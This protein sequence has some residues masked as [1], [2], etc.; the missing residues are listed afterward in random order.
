MCVLE[1]GQG[2]GGRPEASLGK[3]KLQTVE[4]TGVQTVRDPEQDPAF[5]RNPPSQ[6]HCLHTR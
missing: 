6:A 5:L 1:R 4:I 2:V 3:H